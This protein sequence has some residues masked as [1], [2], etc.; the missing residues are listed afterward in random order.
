MDK[1]KIMLIVGI[2]LLI[3]TIGFTV[4][5]KN[6]LFGNFGKNGSALIELK[7][8]DEVNV[9]MIKEIIHTKSDISTESINIENQNGSLVIKTEYIDQTAMTEIEDSLKTEFGDKVEIKAYSGMGK[10]NRLPGF[11]IV[12]LV[13][14]ICFM[15]SIFLLIRNSVS[16]F[17][18]IR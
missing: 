10:P 5:N 7:V 2:V 9:D 8:A 14:L 11:Y 4:V 6:A 13:I 12:Y 1:K 15:L 3:V 18:S 16:I 17:K